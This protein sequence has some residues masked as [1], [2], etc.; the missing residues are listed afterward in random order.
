MQ[1]QCMEKPKYD[2]VFIML[3][4]FHIKMTFFK[5]LRKL[6]SDSECHVA[7]TDTEVLATGSLNGFLSGKNFSRC[8]RLIEL[9]SLAM[10]VLH[11]RGLEN[12]ENECELEDLFTH[13]GFEINPEEI[14]KN[15]MF[16]E[17]TTA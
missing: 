15:K 1:M 5:A 16:I 17:A 8:K 7:L 4:S 12:Y 3:G 2:D 6:I 14:Q 9:L 11:F 13:A 10:E